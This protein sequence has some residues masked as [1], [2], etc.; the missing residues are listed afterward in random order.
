MTAGCNTIAVFGWPDR[1]VIQG[2]SP[3]HVVADLEA[4]H[5]AERER[6]VRIG[7]GQER[8]C[9]GDAYAVDVTQTPALPLLDS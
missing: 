6:L 1:T 7:E 4:E 8:R 5:V 3:T 2:I 9:D